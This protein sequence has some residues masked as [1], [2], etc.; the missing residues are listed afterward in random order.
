MK[1]CLFVFSFKNSHQSYWISNGE[2]L[3]IN[4]DYFKKYT[5]WRCDNNFVK[6][7]FHVSLIYYAKRALV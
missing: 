5:C 1:F 4:Y 6:S 3:S 2:E 7:N